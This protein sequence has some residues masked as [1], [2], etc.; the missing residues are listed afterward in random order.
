MVTKKSV[1]KLTPNTKNGTY[2]CDWCGMEYPPGGWD[3]YQ[4]VLFGKKPHTICSDCYNHL[5]LIK[6]E[7]QRL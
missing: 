3:Y 7:N 5:K 4:I 1:E 2:K 6:A